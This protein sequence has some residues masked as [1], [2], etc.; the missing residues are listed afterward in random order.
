MTMLTSDSIVLYVENVQLS[1]AFYQKV[2]ECEPRLLSPT[3]AVVEF[4][5]N[6]KITLKQAD[7][8]TSSSSVRGGSTELSIPV[9]NSAELDTLFE[10]WEKQCVTLSTYFSMV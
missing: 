3:F 2:F 4:A 8:L 6:E 7:G 5:E 1:M 10:S 9:I